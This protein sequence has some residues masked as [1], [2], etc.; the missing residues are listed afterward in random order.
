[1]STLAQHAFVERSMEMAQASLQNQE[2]IARLGQERVD[3]L[4]EALG[5]IVPIF[6]ADGARRESKLDDADTIPMLVSSFGDETYYVSR[7]TAQYSSRQAIAVE[8]EISLWEPTEIIPARIAQDLIDAATGQPITRLGSDVS[9]N[10]DAVLS[11]P[12]ILFDAEMA[13]STYGLQKPLPRGLVRINFRPFINVSPAVEIGGI[14]PPELFLHE[15]THAGQ[16]EMVPARII[17]SENELKA[18]ELDTELEAYFVGAQVSLANEGIDS[19]TDDVVAAQPHNMQLAVELVRQKFTGSSDPDFSL[20]LRPMLRALERAGLGEARM[21]PNRTSYTSMRTSINRKTVAQ[22]QKP[23]P[24]KARSSS[25]RV[26][27]RKK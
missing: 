12:S 23:V 1:M 14:I 6:S 27:P 3:Y 22:R 5:R 18:I 2:V 9:D 10:S 11:A 20:P 8:R 21:F 24:P 4:G 7:G 26:T 16:K 25:G 15:L 19:V 17:G 13:T